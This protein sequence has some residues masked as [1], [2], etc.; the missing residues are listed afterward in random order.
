[1]HRQCAAGNEGWPPIW[2]AGLGVYPGHDLGDRVDGVGAR[3][4]KKHEPDLRHGMEMI[5]RLLKRSK[6]PNSSLDLGRIA[7]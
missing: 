6:L 7:G 1:M 5:R 3:Q 4:L 2:G